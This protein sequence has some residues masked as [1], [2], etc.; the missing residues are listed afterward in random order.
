MHTSC[1]P[2]CDERV[3]ASPARLSASAEA[4]AAAATHDTAKPTHTTTL[5]QDNFVIVPRP[6]IPTRPTGQ[7]VT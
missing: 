5:R 3:H 2:H 6:Y 4:H 1:P 7:F